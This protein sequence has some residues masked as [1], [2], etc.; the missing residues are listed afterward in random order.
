LRKKQTPAEAVM[1]EILR[2]RKFL[3]L[4]FRRQH[5]IGEYVVDFFCDEHKIAIEL[6]GSVHEEGY[7]GK[8]DKTRGAY[9]RSIG[10][11][12]LRFRNEDLLSNPESALNRIALSCP[13]PAG[14]GV[15][16]EGNPGM[17]AYADI[18]GFCKSASLEEIRKHG[19]V[20]T[21]GRYVG[22]EAVQD[23]LPAPRP[24]VHYV[25]AIACNGGSYYIGHTDNIP[26]RW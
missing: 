19:H 16:G 25:Y 24:G 5:Q 4:K 6:D 1:W 20:L 14:R 12:V 2:D 26:R 13:S 11:K 8:K 15:G 9:L 18:P 10:V 22:A 3:D 23:D 17:A 7:Q 21:P